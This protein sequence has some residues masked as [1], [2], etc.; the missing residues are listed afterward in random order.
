MKKILAAMLSGILALSALSGC[1]TYTTDET[2][3]SAS[4]SNTDSSA[5]GESE[6]TTSGEGTTF[7][8]IGGNPVT[9]NP[10]LSQSTD[11]GNTFYLLQSGL[12]RYYRDEVYNEICDEYTVS[13]DGLVYSFHLRE[14]NWSDGTPIT[15]EQFAYSIQCALNPDMGSPSA[16]TYENVVGAMAYNSGE[17]SWDDVGVKVIDDQNL[18]I[19]LETP[20]DIFILTLA[21]S[22][23]YPLQQ[24]FV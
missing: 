1:G 13:D 12:F 21:T 9:L 14:A 24:D 6:E 22:S 15:A 16:S 7:T 23:L 2:S 19:T 10:I 4:T 3:S 11:D 20:D 5:S 8:F 18:E 17:G